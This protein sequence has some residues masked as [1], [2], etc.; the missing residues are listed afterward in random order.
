MIDP[1]QDYRVK[2]LCDDARIGDARASVEKAVSV[3]GPP[4]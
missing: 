2:Q 3:V 1:V 4:S